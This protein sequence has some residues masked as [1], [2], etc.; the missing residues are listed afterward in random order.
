MLGL[1]SFLRVIKLDPVTDICHYAHSLE[2][3]PLEEWHDLMAHLT[4][5]G[6]AITFCLSRE[7]AARKL[8]R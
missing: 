1:G 4:D 2:G 3:R 5:T 7:I 8:S 6:A